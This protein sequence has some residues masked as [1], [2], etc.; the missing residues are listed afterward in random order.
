V[1]VKLAEALLIWG[2]LT[3]CFAGVCLVAFLLKGRRK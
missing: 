2:M 1:P 3:W